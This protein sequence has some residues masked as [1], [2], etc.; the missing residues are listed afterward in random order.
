MRLLELKSTPKGSPAERFLCTYR[1]FGEAPSCTNWSHHIF[2]WTGTEWGGEAACVEH[3]NALRLQLLERKAK[4]DATL[5]APTRSGR[6]A[7]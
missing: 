5:D 1:P 7:G 2:V 4:D 6:D 3:C